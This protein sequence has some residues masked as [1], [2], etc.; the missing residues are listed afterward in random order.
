MADRFEIEV[1]GFDD[2]R[3]KIENLSND[4]Q[5]KTEITG[6]LRQVAGS[7]V[8][9][10]KALAP[11]SKRAHIARRVKIQ[12]RNLSKSIGVIVGR[13]GQ[14]K[15][16]PTVYVGARVKGGMSGWYAHFVEE[17]TN[18]YSV[19]YVRKNRSRGANKNSGAA[20]RIK[21]GR[22]FLRRAFESTQGKVSSEC[23]VK[24][25]KYIQRRIDRLSK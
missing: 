18:V 4:K 12:P 13:R 3:R 10:A 22:H 2:L 14:A 24:V 11:V 20:V 1:D 21:K 23:A 6:I 25:A 8:N 17:D 9:A 7:T 19:G 16:N 5:K 15:D